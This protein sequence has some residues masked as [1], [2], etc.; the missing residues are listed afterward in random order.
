LSI[1]KLKEANNIKQYRPI[2]LLNV[3]YKWFTKVLT[4]R[5][6][7]YAEKLISN[8]QTAFI[9][10]RYILEGV[11]ILHEIVHELRVTKM[12]GVALKL[13]FEKAY[14]KVHWYF[15]MDVMKKKNFPEKWLTWMKQIIEGGSVGINLNGNPGNFFRTHKGLR[16]GDPLSPL[17][18]NLVSDALAVMLENAKNS[19][20]IKGL[21][22][23][24]I[25]GG[26]THLQY[27]DD[28]VIFMEMEEQTVVNVKFLLYCFENMSGL[29]INYQK[30]EVYV[31]GCTKEEEIKVVEMLNCNVGQLPMK[32]LGVMIHNRHMTVKDLSYI[33][34]KV[35]NRVPTWKSVGLSSG[36]KMV[37]VKSCLS[38]IPN[39]SMG[40]YLLQEEIHH[41]M[42][43]ARANFFW[44]GP[45]MKRKY[46]MA[47]WD[48]MTT[49]KQAG[50][51]GFTNT[52]VMNRCLLAKWIIK[53]ERGENTICCNLLRSKYLGETRI[54]SYKKKSGSQFWKGIMEVRGEV[55]RGVLYIIGNG[56]KVRF[57]KDTWLGVALW[58]YPVQIYL[59]SAT[60]ESGLWPKY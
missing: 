50:G 33:Y 54:F 43:T 44:H 22:P 53:I 2:C 52:R 35:E 51:A 40:I 55:T 46:H 4:M 23:H 14:D 29:K 11:I 39:Y 59:K 60:K 13:D 37:L 1:P 48:L 19:G 32:Y 25:E 56:R 16:Q 58:V 17:L 8:T 49:P 41:K 45:N 42:D 30:S 26:I 36:G 6:T 21:M 9:P 12:K 10:G 20:H 28:T 18:F 7:P 15:M 47:K 5:L 24:L 34:Q 38:S 57:W 27:A 31:L 3:D